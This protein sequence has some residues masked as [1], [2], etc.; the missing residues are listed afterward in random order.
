MLPVKLT[1]LGDYFD[2]QLY[3]G[4][5]YLWT[6]SGSVKTYNWN[7]VVEKLVKSNRDRIA[8]TFSF[9]DC[10]YL[11]NEGTQRILRDKDFYK[12]LVRK[13]K[14]LTS[15]DLQ[16]NEN[17]IRDALI[18]E[19]ETVS[20]LLPIDTEIYN[21]VLYTINDEGFFANRVHSPSTEFPIS[22]RKKKLWDCKLLSIKSNKFGQVALSAG[23]Q[24]LFEYKSNPQDIDLSLKPIEKKSKVFQITK[25]HS[26]FSNYSRLSIYNS[27]SVENSCMALFEWI[28]TGQRAD[29][30]PAYQRSFS[31]SVISD[32][33]IFEGASKLSW[34]S[35]DKIYREGKGKLDVVRFNQ[36]INKESD[37][38]IPRFEH[39]K[40]IEFKP[41]LG[42]VI[43]GGVANFGTIIELMNGIIIEQSNDKTFKIS[44]PITRWRIYP[45]SKLY[46]NHLH[47]ILEDRFVVYSFN[48]DFFIDQKSKVFGTEYTEKEMDSGLSFRLEDL[49]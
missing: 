2:C 6:F 36:F 41:T 19:Q 46:T 23:Y 30:R 3:R 7:K 44:E 49:F 18:G 21:S 27:S 20:G 31:K 24:G 40:S 12:L 11:Y 34:G 47:L 16:L 32:T 39:L 42:K 1:I 5:L 35:G 4:R 26:Q 45:R 29:G 28:Q 8:F 43:S 25:N 10:N 17:E 15:Y 33:E 13:F 14:T 9:L 48:H 38:E 37:I 22:Q